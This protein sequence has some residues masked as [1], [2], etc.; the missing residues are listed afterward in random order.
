MPSLTVS[1][2]ELRVALDVLIPM[3][4]RSGYTPFLD[5]VHLYA[6]PDRTFLATTDRYVIGQW[7]PGVIRLDGEIRVAFPASDAKRIL[8]I[9]PTFR[10]SDED[11]EVTITVDGERISVESATG[12]RIVSKS[13]SGTTPKF[14]ALFPTGEG[15]MPFLTLNPTL[16][17]RFTTAAKRIGQ[18]NNAHRAA[19]MRLKFKGENQAVLIDFQGVTQFRGLLMPM[20]DDR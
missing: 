2:K 4:D 19:G 5:A 8:F 12:E 18:W 15:E 6:T 11:V 9:L 1:G 16:L 7:M 20:R 17:A 13:V 10:H 14:D 3:A